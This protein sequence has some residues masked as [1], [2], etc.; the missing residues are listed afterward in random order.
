MQD[1]YENEVSV[2]SNPRYTK[3]VDGTCSITCLAHTLLTIIPGYPA[4]VQFI[5]STPF[6]IV[7]MFSDFM[8]NL[9]RGV[10]HLFVDATFRP[11][12]ACCSQLLILLVVNETTQAAYPVA[13]I[14]MSC[15]S[16]AAYRTAFQ[17]IVRE[18]ELDLEWITCDFELGLINALRGMHYFWF[19]MHF[20][21]QLQ[22]FFLLPL[23]FCA[24][25][26]LFNQWRVRL[27][28]IG[29]GDEIIG[30]LVCLRH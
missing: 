4:W 7:V 16:E 3:G 28:R 23:L 21:H 30:C 13:F 8:K 5:C 18:L 10:K 24:T 29:E 22:H 19:I 9:C 11:L 20:T 6:L 2:L 25:F 26:T 12:P 27:H 17:F 1:G 14:L 15:K